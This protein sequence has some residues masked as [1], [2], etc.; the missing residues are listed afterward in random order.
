VWLL[1][2]VFMARHRLPCSLLKERPV[3]STVGRWLAH[4]AGNERCAV[5]LACRLHCH[6]ITAINTRI[7]LH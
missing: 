4:D 2:I 6:R 1:S 7:L 5:R 3:K